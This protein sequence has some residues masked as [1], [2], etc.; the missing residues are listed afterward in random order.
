[1]K[2]EYEEVDR[3][4]NLETIETSYIPPDKETVRWMFEYNN[5]MWEI[6]A[7]LLGGWVVKDKITDSFVIKKPRGVKPLMNESG[8]EGTMA[9]INAFANVIQ[10]LTYLT[11]ERILEICRDLNIALAKKYY[12]NMEKY[13]LTPE[14][15][16]IVLRMCMNIIEMNLRKSIQGM[17]MR[18][19]GTTERVIETKTEGKKKFLGII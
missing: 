19:I 2:E 17:S 4:E 16:S 15:A 7:K 6:R 12:I 1:M 9:V 3:E 14:T 5:L 10:G 13:D 8:V 18:I 11:E